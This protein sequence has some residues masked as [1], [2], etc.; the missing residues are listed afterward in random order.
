MTA[1]I[2][3][4]APELH[5]TAAELEHTDAFCQRLKSDGRL[6]LTPRFLQQI[7][8]QVSRALPAL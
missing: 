4:H 5:A 3:A 1:Y 7:R 8:D 6:R 2:A